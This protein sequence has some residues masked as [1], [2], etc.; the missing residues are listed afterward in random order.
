VQCRD[1]THGRNTQTW[2]RRTAVHDC[3]VGTSNAEQLYFPT[4]T[5]AA[6][7]VTP[8]ATAATAAGVAGPA[9]AGSTSLRTA[10]CR[11]VVLA[12]M[13]SDWRLRRRAIG[14]SRRVSQSV[15]CPTGRA[16]STHLDFRAAVGLGRQTG[17]GLTFRFV[18]FTGRMIVQIWFNCSDQSTQVRMDISLQGS[19]I[20]VRRGNWWRRVGC[21]AL[22]SFQQTSH[23][24]VFVTPWHDAVR[25]T[26]PHPRHLPKTVNAVSIIWMSA[27]HCGN[28]YTVDL[29]DLSTLTT[30][31]LIMLQ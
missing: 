21:S 7:I 17:N 16:Y 11:S 18:S 20:Y 15:V 31:H 9:V 24:S 13:S 25:A 3:S 26:C 2:Q 1:E 12:S 27:M 6:R 28:A 10:S 4:G 19:C 30:C 29:H 5:R 22:M 23:V 8:L 14:R